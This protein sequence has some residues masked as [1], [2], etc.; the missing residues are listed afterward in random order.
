MLS[1]RTSFLSAHASLRQR[2]ARLNVNNPSSPEIAN[3]DGEDT[4]IFVI[5]GTGRDAQFWLE[6]E[7]VIPENERR[8][9]AAGKRHCLFKHG[10][11]RGTTTPGLEYFT[12]SIIK[13]QSR[14]TGSIKSFRVRTGIL[15][16]FIEIVK[17]HPEYEPWEPLTTVVDHWM[18]KPSKPRPFIS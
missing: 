14:G 9:D 6:P 18:E 12:T 1:T 2:Q 4:A 10:G 17:L 15:R 16:N 11:L 13:R 5:G 3:F 8:H 7:Q